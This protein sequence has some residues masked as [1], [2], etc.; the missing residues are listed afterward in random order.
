VSAAVDDVSGDLGQSAVCS[1]GSIPKRREGR[2]HVEAQPFGE[3]ALR[4]LDHDAAV[5]RGLMVSDLL[6]Y[7]ALTLRAT[8]VSRSLPNGC[9]RIDCIG[10]SSPASYSGLGFVAFGPFATV[11]SRYRRM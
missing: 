9:A 1:S 11:Q 4:L 3:N 5:Q 2:V 6:G 7:A 8:V 10:P